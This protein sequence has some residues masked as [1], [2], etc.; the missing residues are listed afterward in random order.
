MREPIK[1]HVY[2][3]LLSALLFIPFLGSVHLFDWDEINFAESAREMLVTGNWGIVQINFE[4]FWEKPPLFFWLQAIFMKIFGIGEFAARFPNA[5]AGIVT[6]NFIWYISRKHFTLEHGLWWVLSYIAALTP[7]I[8]FR[9][10]IIDPI[11]NLLIFTAIYQLYLSTRDY[12]TKPIKR[13]FLA[14]IFAGLAILT[15]G[16]VAALLIGMTIVSMIVWK[17]KVFFSLKELIVTIGTALLIVSLWV[18]PAIIQSGPTF[19]VEFINYQLELLQKPVASHGQ[20]WFYHPFVLIIG[21]FPISLIAIP[22]LYRSQHANDFEKWMKCLFWVVLIV[23][24]IVTTKIVHYSSLC[25]FPLTFL[26]ARYLSQI[27]V[28]KISRNALIVFVSILGLVL[29]LVFL[30]IPFLGYYTEE[31]LTYYGHLIKDRFAIANLMAPNQWVGWEWFIPFLFLIGVLLLSRSLLVWNKRQIR[32]SLLILTIYIGLF[33]TAIV[34]RI[35]AYTQASIIDFYEAIEDEDCYVH[36]YKFKTYAHYFYTRLQPLS[37]NSSLFVLKKKYFDEYMA[38]NTLQL[39]QEQKNI[40][41]D[42]QLEFLIN[43]KIDKPVYIICQEKKKNELFAEST[44]TSVY[45]QGGYYVFK[46]TP[47]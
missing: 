32:L 19:L 20:P 34:P 38:Q 8:Y 2:I 13:W 40:F 1:Y 21:C 15:K 46:R 25:Y 17:K 7:H 18:L 43:G 41:N 30:A 22:V 6:L 11:F 44:L 29:L 23:F 9:S 16:P 4:T 10:G 31:F 45:A 36:T 12:E 28:S 5:L 33:T 27:E 24:S 14:G 3:T 35:E 42:K 47:E 37:E 39:T 26:A